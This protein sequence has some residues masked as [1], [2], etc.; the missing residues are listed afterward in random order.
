MSS[1][2]SFQ[3]LASTIRT[4][5]GLAGINAARF[6]V[7]YRT[8][9][10][11]GASTWSTVLTNGVCSE[12]SAESMIFSIENLTSALVSGSPFQN[13]ASW[14]SLN[15]QTVGAMRFHDVASHGI[16]LPSWSRRKSVSKRLLTTLSVGVIV[17]LSGSIVTG[18]TP[19]EMVS[20]ASA[21]RAGARADDPPSIATRHATAKTKVRRRFGMGNLPL[22]D[23]GE[24]RFDMFGWVEQYLRDDG[25]HDCRED[26][27]RDE[28]RVLE[29][30][31]VVVRQAVETRDRPEGQTGRHHQ[32]QVARVLGRMSERARRRPNRNDLPQALNKKER[33]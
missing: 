16:S 7:T 24:F 17:R 33:R 8:V 10:G 19:C 25:R 11:S 20:V 27:P 22:G 13:L 29:A 14:W 18:S 23:A 2:C 31:D 21:A 4:Y 32:R 12:A 5:H 30:V 26:D 1:P 3:Y 9:Y 15:S 28:R 6:A